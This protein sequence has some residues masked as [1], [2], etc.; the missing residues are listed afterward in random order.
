MREGECSLIPWLGLRL[1]VRLH[2]L[3]WEHHKCVSIFF[4]PSSWHRMARVGWS[5]AFSFP[6]S[7]RLWWVSLPW[8]QALLGRT[9]CSLF[10]LFFFF[11]CQKPKGVLPPYLLREFG[12][13]ARGKSPP[14]IGSLWSCDS[15]LPVYTDLPVVHQFSSDFPT[16]HSLPWSFPHSAWTPCIYLFL[17]SWGHWCDLC[18]L[19]SGIS[20]IPRVDDF[21][22]FPD[23]HLLEW[24]GS[25]QVHYIRNW[26][27]E[28]HHL[29]VNF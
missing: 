17:R 2:V 18:L 9:S 27:P 14:V 21:S 22:D 20:Q 10:K 4:S 13:G 7:V 16:Q 29:N 15:Q 12:Q 23:F 6:S 24:S 11:S 26:K 5:W 28:V 8:K 19:F 25:L 1:L 3:D